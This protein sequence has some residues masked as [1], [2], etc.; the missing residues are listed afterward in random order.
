[1]PYT[2]R[3]DDRTGAEEA[4][5]PREMGR[6]LDGLPDREGPALREEIST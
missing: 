6:L 1:M 5:D 4:A 2:K 3:R